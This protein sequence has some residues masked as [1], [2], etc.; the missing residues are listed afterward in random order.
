[1]LLTTLHLPEEE[2][3]CLY[4]G[5][6]WSSDLPCKYGTERSFDFSAYWGGHPLLLFAFAEN[7]IAIKAI[8]IIYINKNNKMNIWNTRGDKR[9][10]CYL[11]WH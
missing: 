3:M 8:Y 1:M 11:W 2:P 4:M 5:I 7:R 6:L 9:K 10:Y